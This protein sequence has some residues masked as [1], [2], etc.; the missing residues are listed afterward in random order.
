MLAGAPLIAAIHASDL[1][2]GSDLAIF[3]SAERRAAAF[4]TYRTSFPPL[5]LRRPDLPEKLFFSDLVIPLN[6]VLDLLHG[7]SAGF[8]YKPLG[9]NLARLTELAANTLL[10]QVSHMYPLNALDIPLRIT[11]PPSSHLPSID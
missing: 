4:G 8:N 2:I 10:A 5:V 11:M 6:D 7:V 3:Y 1:H 9:G